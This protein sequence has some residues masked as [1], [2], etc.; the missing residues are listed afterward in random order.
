MRRRQQVV[1]VRH[2]DVHRPNVTGALANNAGASFQHLNFSTILKPLDVVKYFFGADTAFFLD[3][4]AAQLAIKDEL[5]GVVGEG[6]VVF[7]DNALVSKRA[8]RVG[9]QQRGFAEGTQIILPDGFDF[10]L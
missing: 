9:Q 10:A 7:D 8:A 4:Y 3:A 2:D 6:H 5:P 1:A